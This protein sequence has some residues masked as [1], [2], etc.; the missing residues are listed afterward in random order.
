MRYV[1]IIGKTGNGFSAHLPDLPGC[2]AAADTFEETASLIQ[3]AANYHVELMAEGGEPIPQP[4]FEAV[5][6]EIPE[7]ARP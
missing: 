4:A 5:D 1:A 3:E 2:V 7:P 6:I